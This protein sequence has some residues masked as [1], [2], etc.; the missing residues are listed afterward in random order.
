MRQENASAQNNALT[1]SIDLIII[2]RIE[3]KIFF[4]ECVEAGATEDPIW[5]ILYTYQCVCIF[6]ADTL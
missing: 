6:Y 1:P 5:I 2:G 4:A 3:P